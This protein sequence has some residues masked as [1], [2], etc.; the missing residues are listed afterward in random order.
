MKC[1]YHPQVDAVAICKHC[2]RG[3]CADCALEVSG[4]MACKNGLLNCPEEVREAQVVALRSRKSYQNAP[5]TYRRGALLAGAIGGTMTLYGLLALRGLP[6]A[7]GEAVLPVGVALLLL[8]LY[9]VLAA[10]SYTRR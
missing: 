6:N 7:V 4:G 10:R 2:Q 3:L 1:Y 8:C 5:Q 9:W